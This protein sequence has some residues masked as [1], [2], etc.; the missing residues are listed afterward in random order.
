MQQRSRSM[1][2][3]TLVYVLL[4][5]PDTGRVADPGQLQLNQ[6]AHESHKNFTE[7]K[8]PVKLAASHALVA[9]SSSK[10]ASFERHT[11]QYADTGKFAGQHFASSKTQTPRAPR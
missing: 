2:H 8:G 9:S 5:F 11:C 1:A 7:Q 3:Y 6:N 10:A 4:N